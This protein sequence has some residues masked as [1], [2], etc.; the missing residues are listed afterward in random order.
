MSNK[1]GI[2]MGGDQPLAKITTNVKNGKK[3]AVIKDSYA[4]AFIPFLLPH[5]EEIY[6]VDPR[7]YTH[8]FLDLV[9][10][11]GIQNVLIL[12]YSFITENNGFADLMREMVTR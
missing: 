6:V 12:N 1:Y 10:K 7:Q 2:F 11:N 9:K 5:Y 4:N 8:N 3:I